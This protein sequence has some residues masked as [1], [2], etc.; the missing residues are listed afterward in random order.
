MEL[1]IEINIDNAAF[2]PC[3]CEEVTRILR[4]I[5]DEIATHKPSY[6]ALKMGMFNQP[7]GLRDV[8]G[9]KVGYFRIVKP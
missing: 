3:P 6:E 1:V 4:T 2:D 5:A 8:N 7:V 9:N